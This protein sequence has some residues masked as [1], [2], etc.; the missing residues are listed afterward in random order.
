[1]LIAAAVLAAALVRTTLMAEDDPTL[2]KFN[3]DELSAANA[4]T[5]LPYLEFLRVS[6][7]SGYIYE[8]PA[9]AVD[10]QNPHDQDEVYYVV[11]GRANLTADGETVSVEPGDILFVKKFADH[12]FSEISEDLR[13][14]V[15]FAP[16]DSD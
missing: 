12:R 6:T 13:L 15:I 2:L 8:L 4:S 3:I 9:G 14:L 5:D 11:S 16:P 1:M 10:E 7:M